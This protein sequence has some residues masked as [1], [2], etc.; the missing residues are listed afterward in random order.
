MLMHI[1]TGSMLHEYLGFIDF[2]LST[3]KKREHTCSSWVIICVSPSFQ[4][5]TNGWHTSVYTAENKVDSQYN[6]L[7]ISMCI[8][9]FICF[10][11]EP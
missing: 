11:E 1:I 8:I 9:N 4:V 3:N 10:M 2:Q 6:I 5:A 7:N